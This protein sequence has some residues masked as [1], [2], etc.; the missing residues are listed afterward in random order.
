MLIL[1]IPAGVLEP[2]E[3]IFGPSTPNKIPL[4]FKTLNA[5]KLI[6][7]HE[8]KWAGKFIL[9]YLLRLVFPV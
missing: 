8:R 4:L 3:R 5:L 2:A 7:A 6:V 9:L 1:G